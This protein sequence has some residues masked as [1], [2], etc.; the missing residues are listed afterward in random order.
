M[1]RNRLKDRLAAGE[2]MCGCFTRHPAPALVELLA[3]QG[4]DFVVIDAEH[5]PIEPQQCEDLV[6]AAEVRDIPAFVRVPRN[7]PS[8]IL[9]YLDTGALG[10]HVPMVNSAADAAQAVDATYY[11]PKGNRGLASVRA[12]DYGQRGSLAEYVNE[13]NDNLL[14]VVQVETVA[15]CR[16]IEE[17]GAVEGVDVVFVGPTDLSQSVGAPGQ[18][19]DPRVVAAVKAAVEAAVHSKSAAGIFVPDAAT[20]AYWVGLG[21]TYIAVPVEALVSRASREFLADVRQA[22]RTSDG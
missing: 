21:A 4:W 3:L 19:D 7:S 1:K 12:A 6:R 15:A 2:V 18:R 9:R 13:A 20:A 10:L 14:T 8:V 5:G 16:R 11:H 17:I 22:A